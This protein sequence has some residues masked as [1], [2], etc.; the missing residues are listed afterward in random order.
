MYIPV[1]NEDLESTDDPREGD[2]AV[3]LPRSN[4]GRVLHEDDEVV[5]VSLVEDLV[6][7]D[8]SASHCVLLF[9]GC[10]WISRNFEMGF[11]GLNELF[12]CRSR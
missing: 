3:L 10:R 6:N 1:R 12:G 5:V 4:H 7:S 9:M 11:G 2:G 8:V